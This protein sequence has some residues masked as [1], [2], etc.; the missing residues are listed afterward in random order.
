MIQR[1]VPVLQTAALGERTNHGNGHRD[2]PKTQS[3]RSEKST[4]T[5]FAAVRPV[6]PNIR[7]TYKSWTRAQELP[8]TDIHLILYGGSLKLV[9]QTPAIT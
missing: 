5:R 8:K 9:A 3:V 6:K 1:N 7:Y 4:A 2:K